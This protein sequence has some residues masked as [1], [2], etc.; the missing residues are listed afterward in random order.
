MKRLVTL[1]CVCALIVIATSAPAAEQGREQLVHY[2]NSLGFA[3]MEQRVRVIAQIQTR[4]D[5]ERRKAQVHAKILQLIGGLPE[6]RGPLGVRQAGTLQRDGFRVEKII[7]E[8]F[9]GMYVTANVYVP[10]TGGPYPAVVLTAGHDATGKIGQYEWGANLARN[11]IIALAY[12]PIGEGERIQNFDADLEVSKVGGV[13]GEH[14]HAAIQTMLLGEHVARYFIWDAMRAIDYLS[15]RSDVDANRIGAFGCSGGGTVTTYLAAL[16]DRV[17]AAASA[18]YITSF[19]ELLPTAGPQE[20]EQSIPHFLEE[21]LDFGDWVELAAPKPYAIVSTTNDMFPFEGARQTYEEAKRIYGLYGASDKIQWITGPGGHGALAPISPDILAFFVKWLK[22]SDEHP[23]FT[24]LRPERPEDL[25]CTA[26]GQVSTS[27]GGE[28]VSSLN[29]KRA[30]ELL[31]LKRALSGSDIELLRAKLQQDIKAMAMIT[32]KPGSPPPSVTTIAT[33]P[34]ENYQLDTISM[35]GED[36]ID[37]PGMIALPKGGGMKAAVLM[38]DTRALDRLSA[39]NSDMDRLANSGHV[40]MVL[41]PRP[42]PAGT[43]NTQSPLLGI[44]NLLGL[45]SVLVGKTLMGMRLEDALH[46]L[47]WLGS[48]PEVDR[49]NIAAYGYGPLGVVALHAAVLDGRI[50]KLVLENTLTSYRMIV[51][52]PIH[53]NAPEVT[54]LGVLRKYDLGD[55]MLAMHPRTVAVINP[56]DALGVSVREDSFGKQLAY[57]F[58]SAHNLRFVRRAAGEPLP[59][60]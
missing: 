16:D 31:P 53:R 37:V 30:A 21:G 8:S 15:A 39:P 34:K 52:Q 18:C 50:G 28:T 51:D 7:Y 20:A 57:V 44:Y 36:G 54:L 56:V 11:G 48:R 46:A 49:S 41:Q 1:T 59:I 29:K 38:L 25:L 10:G 2:L 58:D 9:P 24:R 45:R 22:N 12:D 23:A 27:L 35:R 60:D 14:G 33:S 6:T 42:T 40:V 32:V 3:R 47:D 43:D 4:A 19:K 26:T 13:T 5:A 55:L 17:K